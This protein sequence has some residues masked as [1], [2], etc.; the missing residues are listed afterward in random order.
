MLRSTLEE[1]LA[2]IKGACG[3]KIC[4]PSVKMV[5]CVKMR[6]LCRNFKEKAGTI[7][8]IQK[9]LCFRSGCNVVMPHANSFSAQRTV[10]S[11]RWKELNIIF[12]LAESRD[13][14]KN[15]LFP[16]RGTICRNHKRVCQK[17]VRAIRF[18]KDRLLT[19]FQPEML[20]LQAFLPCFLIF[21]SE[22]C[23]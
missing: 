11:K 12:G 8:L 18:I 1:S 13:A 14:W 10:L 4:I 22:H 3:K 9:T 21:F 6:T 23:N 7:K 5:P 16:I 20:P 15:C 19:A 2:E 17:K